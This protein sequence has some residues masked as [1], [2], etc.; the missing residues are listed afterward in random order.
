MSSSLYLRPPT[1]SLPTRE[2]GLKYLQGQFD[3]AVLV[4]APHAG[5]WIE[6]LCPYA[7]SGA[8]N[9]APHAGAWIEIAH[10]RCYR[11]FFWSLP[12]RE[13]GLKYQ[14]YLGAILYK[15]SLPTRERGLKYQSPCPG[16][17]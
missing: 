4:V 11:P 7:P 2:R 9:V 10:I 5:A 6:M 17:S 14:W 12:T 15:M 3:L 16:S 13:R 8:R 1:W